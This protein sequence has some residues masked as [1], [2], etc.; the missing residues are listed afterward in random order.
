MISRT[1]EYALRAIVWLAAHGQNP[2]T[3]RQI[4]AATRVPGGYLSKVMQ[5]LVDAGI[6]NSQRGPGGGFVLARPAAALTVLEVVDAVDP[7]RRIE[8]CP[9]GLR[10]HAEQLCALHRRL[11]EAL[12]MIRAAFSSCTVADLLAGE[13]ASPLCEERSSGPPAAAHGNLAGRVGRG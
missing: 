10:S 9:L 11:D 12:A 5:A 2:R 7:I 1:T 4:A 13:G 6:V 8:S 3:T